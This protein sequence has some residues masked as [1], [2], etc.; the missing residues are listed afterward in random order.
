MRNDVVISQ[1]YIKRFLAMAWYQRIRQQKVDLESNISTIQE[2]IQ[3]YNVDAGEF[4]ENFTGKKITE[5]L[6]YLETFED[7]EMVKAKKGQGNL[8]VPK[9]AQMNDEL[10]KM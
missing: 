1:Q 6:K 8:N 2:L 5:P 7:Y 4:K 3:K 10:K 9:M